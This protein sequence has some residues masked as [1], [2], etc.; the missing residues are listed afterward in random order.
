MARRRLSAIMFADIAG[1]TA[2]MQRN[3]DEAVRSRRKY[4]DTTEAAVSD[5]NGEIVHFYGDGA[6]CLFPSA[7][8]AVRGA[9]RIQYTLNQDPAVPVR[10]CIHSV[11]VVVDED[12][13]YGDGVNIASRVQALA[14]P[15]SIC[16]SDTVYE[17]I[18]NQPSVQTRSLGAQRL[19]NVVRPVEIYAI[20]DPAIPVT[21]SKDLSAS[22][23]PTPSSQESQSVAVLPFKNMSSDEENEYFSD[24]I[25]EEIIN[26]LT[27]VGNL[28]VTS[29]TSSF[30]FKGTRD[31]VRE[32]A[33]VLG[34]SHVLEGSVRKSGERVRITAQLIK[35]ADDF[36]VFSR[37]YDRELSDIFKIQDEISGR[38]ADALAESLNPD[39]ES[40]RESAPTDV[41]TYAIYLKGRHH[42]NSWSPEGAARSIE[43][44]E[45]AIARSP[46]YPKPYAALAS[47]YAFLAA[48]GRV[49]DDLSYSR[50][51]EVA[52]KAVALDPESGEAYV[53]L[54]MVAIFRDWDA[55]S[56]R[57]HLEKAVSIS[58]GSAD[59][60]YALGLFHAIQ[61]EREAAV[62]Q[63]K[64]AVDLDPL[65]LH[66][67]TMY[68]NSLM[69]AGQ[70]QEALDELG[71]VL[72]IDPSFR[73]AWESVGMAHW[74]RGD[75]EEALSAFEEFSR[76][77]PNPYAGASAL[78]CV[79]AGMGDE[80]RAREQL[81]RLEQ[82]EAS[83]NQP[84][85]H[86]D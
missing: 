15:G 5:F 79:Y 49:K 14:V 61:L 4:R 42:W 1:Y 66:S 55:T 83:E 38:I 51:K 68:A 80:E 34:V 16:V 63:L 37:T 43:L 6:L 86:Q 26:A 10:I 22:V 73:S 47:S 20:V 19:K 46:D 48:S 21:G 7:V 74:M 13:A 3:E 54:G 29:R 30:A 52:E 25:T 65:S 53:A 28:K 45:K 35:A 59:T 50:A 77:S 71:Q 78:G 11:D 24:G 81:R 60:R 31:N 23:A 8:E 32:I 70:I 56:A 82:R 62:R 75:H 69:L 67:R 84:I 2:M 44:Y 76:L 41:T 58:P 9:L 12:G 33:T 85:L 57:A 36:H 27:S 17:E 72:E 18:K 39:G 40:S 64:R